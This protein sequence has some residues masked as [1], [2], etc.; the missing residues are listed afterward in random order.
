MKICRNQYFLGHSA[1]C[2]HLSVFCFSVLLY[3]QFSC[4]LSLQ[5]YW[6]WACIVDHADLSSGRWVFR[7]P[8]GKKKVSAIVALSSFILYF[9]FCVQILVPP[10]GLKDRSNDIR[11]LRNQLQMLNV[12]NRNWKFGVGRKGGYQVTPLRKE[13]CFTL[14]FIL[15]PSSVAF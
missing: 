3:L 15:F 11:P 8:G 6:V 12:T 10:S 1:H 5:I 2:N 13:P 14:R 4:W 9:K 7:G